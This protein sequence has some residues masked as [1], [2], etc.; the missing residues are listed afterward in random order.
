MMVKKGTK[1]QILQI[2]RFLLLS[3]MINAFFFFFFKSK[4]WL[5]YMQ[6]ET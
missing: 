6:S 4:K 1:L 3:N 5:F 2:G